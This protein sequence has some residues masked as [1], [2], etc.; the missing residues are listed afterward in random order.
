MCVCVCEEERENW[1]RLLSAPSACLSLPALSSLQFA[2]VWLVY[3]GRLAGGVGQAGDTMEPLSH[4][5]CSS[6]SLLSLSLSSHKL[7]L[8]PNLI[9]S[10]PPRLRCPFSCCWR[11]WCERVITLII[12]IYERWQYKSGETQS[13]GYPD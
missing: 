1:I 9:L 6:R 2:L 4:S 8:L 3:C 12:I 10:P 5:L 7:W 11:C 13:D